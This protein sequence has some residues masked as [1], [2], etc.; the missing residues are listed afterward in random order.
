MLTEP[1]DSLTGKLA[2]EKPTVPLTL[3]VTAVICT[4]DE[5]VVA[6]V[7]TL[8]ALLAAPQA[9]TAEIPNNQINVAFFIRRP[10][11]K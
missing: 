10:S 4:E 7:A 6:V 3:A 1:A 2:P 8:L 5:G 11:G 9:D